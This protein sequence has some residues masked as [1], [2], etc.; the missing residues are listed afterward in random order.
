[1]KRVN[2]FGQ[3]LY[4]TSAIFVFVGLMIFGILLISNQ[5]FTGSVISDVELQEGCTD[6]N[7][8]NVWDSIFWESSA[9]IS[10]LKNETSV[11]GYC[12]EFFASK[13]DSANPNRTY[14]LYSYS[15]DSGDENSTYIVAE[16]LNATDR[17]F[18][19][20]LNNVNS[21]EDF[22]IYFPVKNSTYFSSYVYPR[23]V[24]VNNSNV[25][26][27][28]NYS[29]EMNKVENWSATTYLGIDSY[30]FS[31]NLSNESFSRYYNGVIASDYNYAGLDF[32]FAPL[33]NIDCSWITECGSW[34]DCIDGERNRTCTNSSLCYSDVNYTDFD[35]CDGTCT[36]LW[37]WSNWSDCDAGTRVRSVWDENDC[38]N[39]TGRPASSISC[40]LTCVADWD[41]EEWIPAV[42]NE[43]STQQRT[44]SDNNFCDISNSIK[45][46]TRNC[47]EG[48][49]IIFEELEKEGSGKAFILVLVIM[50]LLIVGVVVWLVFA[51]RSK[52][53]SNS[54]GSSVKNIPPNVPPAKSLNSSVNVPSISRQIPSNIPPRRPAPLK[55]P[56]FGVRKIPPV[57][58]QRN[59][60]NRP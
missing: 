1:M 27:S 3:L 43:S 57:R 28:F 25:G 35:D 26:S 31:N 13:V 24:D 2:C 34:S 4:F 29:F 53:G 17:Y 42:C 15:T 36:Q 58:V 48:E 40:S 9:G 16:V 8:Q 54:N 55:F 52:D 45:I 11:G 18:S 50:G 20:F 10:I 59:F 51:I 33:S 12:S 46:E 39:E 5:V 38:D 23:N 41:C 47:T 22:S 60:G 56:R 19:D 30:T 7:I 32:S 6:S 14:I 49:P 44:C 37:N 21:I